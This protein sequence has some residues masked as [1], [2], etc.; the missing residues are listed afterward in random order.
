MNISTAVHLQP[1]H[2]SSP[3]VTYTRLMKSSTRLHP[4]RQPYVP[5]RMV[6]DVYGKAINRELLEGYAKVNECIM[7]KDDSMARK[8]DN[9]KKH[10]VNLIC[11]KLFL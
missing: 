7:R 8:C 1:S 6:N 9:T 3:A 2:Y 11:D 5:L 4:L 10:S